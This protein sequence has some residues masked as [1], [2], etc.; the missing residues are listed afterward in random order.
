MSNFS[1]R[2]KALRQETKLSQ[3]QLS[4]SL[5]IP[6]TTIS[7][8]ELGSRQA[9]TSSINALCDFFHVSS[10]YLLGR[11]DVRNPLESYALN[12]EL[13]NLCNSLPGIESFI[14]KFIVRKELQLICT[15]IK[16]IPEDS[17]FKLA[18]IAQILHSNID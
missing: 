10:D 18:K 4:A 1:E 2:L 6:R 14:K 9:D 15:E 16:D 11:I 3:E 5:N 7:S 8:W 12:N 17:L 13:T